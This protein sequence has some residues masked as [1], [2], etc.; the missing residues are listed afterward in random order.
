MDT[1]NSHMGDRVRDESTGQFVEKHPPEEFVDAI[2][3]LGGSAGTSEIA[4]AV[5]AEYDAAYK[6]L[7]NLADAGRIEKQKVANANLW[8]L[9]EE[10]SKE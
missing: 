2:Q 3:D 9:T 5:G 7:R 6:K 4:D 10:E 1:R 8:R